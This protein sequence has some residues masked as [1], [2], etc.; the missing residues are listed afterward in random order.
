MPKCSKCGYQN[1]EGNNY[2]VNC[3]SILEITEEYIKAETAK[4][5][6]LTKNYIGYFFIFMGLST[7]FGGCMT[8]ATSVGTIIQGLTARVAIPYIIIGF[9]FLILG[10][11]ILLPLGEHSNMVE[12]VKEKE[13]ISREL[14]QTVLYDKLQKIYTNNYDMGKLEREITSLMT[15]QQLSRSEAIIKLAEKEGAISKSS[16]TKVGQA[17]NKM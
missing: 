10:F 13:P 17:N 14:S 5:K 2:C 3:G 8:Y 15:H 12:I 9:I 16:L 6:T 4:K 1:K 11:G 7:F